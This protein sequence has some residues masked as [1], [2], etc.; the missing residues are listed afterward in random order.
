MEIPK[1]LKVNIDHKEFMCRMHQKTVGLPEIFQR[2]F[3]LPICHHIRKL[4]EPVLTPKVQIKGSFL[5]SNI[6]I[7]RFSF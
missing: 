6:K 4:F 1:I 2:K 7:P 3:V 5:V